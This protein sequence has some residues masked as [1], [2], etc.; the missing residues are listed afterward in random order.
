MALFDSNVHDIGGRSR[1]SF[2]TAT[3]SRPFVQFPIFTSS[4]VFEIPCAGRIAFSSKSQILSIL[5][6]PPYFLDNSHRIQSRVSLLPAKDY[7]VTQ[8][9]KVFSLIDQPVLSRIVLT[10]IHPDDTANIIARTNAFWLDFQGVPRTGLAPLE[11]AF[12]NL[13]TY[14]APRWLWKFGDG[15]SSSELSPT[16]TYLRRG[17]YTVSLAAF[18]VSGVIKRAVKVDYIEVGSPL[19]YVQMLCLEPHRVLFQEDLE[20]LDDSGTIDT[21]YNP[22]ATALLAPEHADILRSL[23]V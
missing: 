7:F 2:A 11:V 14:P 8:N 6:D 23:M 10:K 1:I 3:F 20:G 18:D 4:N 17:L 19:N 13:S 5:I 22:A 9:V 16:H 21:V 12:V 15:G